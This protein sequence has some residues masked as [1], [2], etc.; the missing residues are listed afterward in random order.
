M[1][2]YEDYFDWEDD[3]SSD[4]NEDFKF[5]DIFGSND[6]LFGNDDGELF[7][8]NT[9]KFI[10]IMDKLEKL[11]FKRMIDENFQNIK[12]NGIDIQFLLTSEPIEN[13]IRLID[14]LEIMKEHFLDGEEYE[15]MAI[16]CPILDSI[17]E[18]IKHKI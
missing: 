2:E 10:E 6:D 18:K 4:D 11:R 16:I 1:K 7:E 8:P 17:N 12:R 9:D 15:K 14:T 3:D 5:D 13:V